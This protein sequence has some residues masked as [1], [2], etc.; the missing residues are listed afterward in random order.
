MKKLALLLALFSTTAMADRGYEHHEHYNQSS[1]IA[2]ALIG[3]IIGY[4]LSQPRL[5]Q[6]QPIYVP[7]PQ[8]P[9]P[10]YVPAAPYGYHWQM[11]IDSYTNE[12]RMVAVPNQ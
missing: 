3:G 6:Q 12:Q 8:A 7:V 2:P 10:P 1:W 9:P 5:V 11:M 4:E